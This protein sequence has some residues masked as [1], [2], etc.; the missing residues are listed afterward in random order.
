MEKLTCTTQLSSR[1]TGRSKA[2]RRPVRATR[3]K[4][5]QLAPGYIDSSTLVIDGDDEGYDEDRPLLKKPRLDTALVIKME[6]DLQ[7]NQPLSAINLISRSPTLA[8][9]P[10]SLT[11]YPATWSAVQNFNKMLGLAPDGTPRPTKSSVQ[12][13]KVGPPTTKSLIVKV[14]LPRGIIDKN[15]NFDPTKVGFMDLPGELRNEVY[16][17]VFKKNKNI[18][19]KGRSGFSHS[20]AFLRVNKQVHAEA[21]KILYGENRFVFSHSVARLGKYYQ[22]EWRETGYGHVREFLS[23][24][25]PENTSLIT[26]I[27]IGFEDGTPSGNPGKTTNQRRFEY[28]EDVIWILK[29]LSNYGKIEKLKLGF[30]GRRMFYGTTSVADFLLALKGVKTDVLDYGNP[31]SIGEETDWWVPSH[32]DLKM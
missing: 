1:P 13:R 30:S 6:D 16:A 19:F 25:G 8:P 14:L 29:H 4:K 27:G 20:S 24:I 7:H 11:Y 17:I 26:N 18:E 12:K 2:G 15:A 32:Y 3:D 22:Q 31:S 21:R 10:S 5:P 23:A 28:N 9:D